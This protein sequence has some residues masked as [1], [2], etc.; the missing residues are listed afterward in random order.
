MEVGIDLC[1]ACRNVSTLSLIDYTASS[2][3]NQR[4]FEIFPGQDEISFESFIER[5]RQKFDVLVVMEGLIDF[6]GVEFRQP[7]SIRDFLEYQ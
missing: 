5:F 3:K 6:L 7:S 4:F 1:G 2:R